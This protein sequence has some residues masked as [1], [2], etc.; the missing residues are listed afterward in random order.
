MSM[1]ERVPSLGS[2]ENPDCRCG[3]EMSLAAVQP[4]ANAPDTELRIMYV[5]RS[6]TS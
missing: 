3:A 2:T 6:G 5:L 1:I 4:S